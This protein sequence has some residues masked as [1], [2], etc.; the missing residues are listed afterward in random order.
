MVQ[1]TIHKH[2]QPT[3]GVFRFDPETSVQDHPPRSMSTDM[4]S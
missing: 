1:V 2:T 4:Q 3:P